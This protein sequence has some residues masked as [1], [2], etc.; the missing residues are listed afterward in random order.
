MRI[1][2]EENFPSDFAKLLHG[3]EVLTVHR[4]GWS[5][6]KNGELLRKAAGVCEVFL[7]LDGNLG[8][9]QN[10]KALPFGVVHV[11]SRSNRLADLAVH[12]PSILAAV[13]R[14]VPGKLEA[15]DA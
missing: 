13:A 11:R 1:L 10:V 15:A 14:A 9:Q 7:T 4:L 6:L 12:I 5:G 3:H 8:Y 2:I